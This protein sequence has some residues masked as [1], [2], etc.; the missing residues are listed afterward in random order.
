MFVGS[1]NLFPSGHFLLTNLL[2]EKMKST[3]RKMGIEG[4]IVNLSSIAHLH[5]YDEGI[6]FDNLSDTDGYVSA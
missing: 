1:V 5:S 2:L 6:R 4:R 3:A